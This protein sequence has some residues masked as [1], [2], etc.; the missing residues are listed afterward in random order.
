MQSRSLRFLS[1]LFLAASAAFPVSAEEIKLEHAGLTVNANLEAAQE[2]WQSGTVVLLTHGTLAHNGLEIITTLQGLLT[3]QGVSSLALNLSLGLDDR[4]GMY[5]CA[6]PH[7][8]RHTDALDEIGTWLGWLKAQ[9]VQRVVLVGHSRG[10]NQTAWFAAERLNPVVKGVVL[11]APAT[12][13]ERYAVDDYKKR[14]DTD[15]APVLERAEKLVAAGKGS[16][17]LEGTGFV[18]CPGAKVQAQAFVS[19]HAP[20]PRLDAPGLLG[21]IEVP[22]LVVAGTLDDVVP[23]VAEKVEPHADGERVRLVVIDGA[24]HFFRDLNAD[25]LVEHA[26]AFIDSL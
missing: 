6:V 9:G 15:L 8:H 10:G 16:E 11:I 24:D 5:D 1:M 12:W 3:E 25:E 17:W 26:K 13:S 2:N 21:S 19:Y 20:E 7:T 22:V 14:F 23:D 4:H 18:Y